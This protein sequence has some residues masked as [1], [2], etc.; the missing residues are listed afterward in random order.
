M[1][2]LNSHVQDAQG[3]GL[4]ARGIIKRF[5]GVAALSGVDVA[6]RP[7][8]VVGLV[9]HNGAGKST[10]MKVLSGA[11]RPDEGELSVDGV[12]LSFNGPGDALAVGVSTVYQELSLLDNLTVAQNIYLGR[13]TTH[14]GVLN[15][16][17]MK[18]HAQE[19]VEEFDLDVDVGLPLGQY[20]VAVR[21]LLEIAVATARDT[22]YLLLDEPTTSLEGGQVNVFLKR[23]AVLARDKNIGILLVDHKLDEL[24]EVAHDIVALVD[25]SVR[26]SGP[27]SDIERADIVRAIAGDEAAEHL[28]ASGQFDKGVERAQR[29]AVAGNSGKNLKQ[30]T[31]TPSLSVSH[32][33][34]HDLEDVSF[35]AYDGRVLGI[36]GLIGSG[37]TELLRTLVG[38][39]TV[40]SGE[41]RL[42][43]D[44]YRPHSPSSAQAAGLV[45]LTEERKVDGIVPGLDSTM[46]VVLPV[47][48]RFT[49]F[50]VIDKGA[51]A[52]EG[53]TLMDELRVR[54]N[55]SAPVASLSGGNQQKVLFARALGQHPKLL[56]LD[57]PTKGV[58]IGVKSEIHRMMR[59]LAHVQGLTVIV[60]SSEEDEIL[61][62][63]DD[64][65]TFAGGTCDGV[66]RPSGDLSLSTLRQAA[67]EAA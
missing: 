65:I 32:L 51:M 31:G 53:T 30:R 39:E 2:G 41:I 4:V 37:R 35:D 46:N 6:V 22:K 11:L 44:E 14:R 48:G 57:E 60:V 67:W 64:V 19:L 47:L 24:Y 29:A 27:A 7:G 16:R 17:A 63:A 33:R 36:Y 54:G 66:S 3:S 26:I 12:E 1:A 8:Q 52:R 5:S 50:G 59:D 58:D 62:V 20:P 38:L 55:R 61:D 10:L 40:L 13:E 42:F 49:K 23:I 34:T 43:G 15:R 45:Y 9:G 18:A 21:Q 25:G 28:L 56:L